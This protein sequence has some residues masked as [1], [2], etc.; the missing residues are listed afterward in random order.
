MERRAR[1]VNIKEGDVRGEGG[2]REERK[3]EKNEKKK[4]GKEEKEKES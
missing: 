2:M 1:S 3:L 4:V